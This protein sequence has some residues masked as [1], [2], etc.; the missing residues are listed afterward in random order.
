MQRCAIVDLDSGAVVNA[1]EYDDAPQGV[2]PGMTGNLIAIAHD[3]AGPGW[4]YEAGALI[5]PEPAPPT[6]PPVPAVISDRQFFQLLA[7]RGHITPEEAKAALGTGT[8]PAV[9]Q[10][11][12]DTLT[13]TVKFDAECKL[14]G[15]TQ[16]VRSS[17]TTMAFA[18]ALE[19]DAAWLD[20]FWREAAA[21]E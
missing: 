12:V 4:R 1:I 18:A 5:A 21:L 17:A 2:P 13:G 8:I 19:K 15:A 11:F 16:F 6:P 20:A 14:I 9:L 3:S 7:L 10:D